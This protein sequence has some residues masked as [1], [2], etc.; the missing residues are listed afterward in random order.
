MRKPFE[1]FKYQASYILVLK[2]P[3][4]ERE[5]EDL[6]LEYSKIYDSP[7]YIKPWLTTKF[8]KFTPEVDRIAITE[9]I[10]KDIFLKRKVILR[11]S[12]SH[13]EKIL[14]FHLFD[15]NNPN[16][17]ILGIREKDGI[18]TMLTRDE[19]P[20]NDFISEQEY[21]CPLSL[22][23]FQTLSE[24]MPDVVRDI[25]GKKLEKCFYLQ[26]Q[27]KRNYNKR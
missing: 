5:W 4:S 25:S 26:D 1:N 23:T 16:L 22:Y 6:F 9:Y 14:P 20:K 11:K 12:S 21:Y 24:G 10:K 17:S 15:W 8:I 13:S 3:L 19:N 27:E 7:D 18:C 2:Y